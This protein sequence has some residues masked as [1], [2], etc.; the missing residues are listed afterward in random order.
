MNRSF[1]TKIAKKM[2]VIIMNKN[3]SGHYYEQKFTYVSRLYYRLN[4]LV[5]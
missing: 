1:N 4:T 3:S 5:F 2:Y